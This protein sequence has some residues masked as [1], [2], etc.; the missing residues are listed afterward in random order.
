MLCI[1]VL[2]ICI[3]TLCRVVHARDIVPHL[4]P[5]CHNWGGG[6]GIAKNCPYHAATEVWYNNDMAQNSSYTIC[7]TLGEDTSCDNVINLSVTDHEYYFGIHIGGHC[8]EVLLYT[9][10]LHAYITCIHTAL[11]HSNGPHCSSV[12]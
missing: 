12:H 9:N 3:H 4:A 7:G 11:M 5:C 1:T 8:G 6:C 2:F 10:T